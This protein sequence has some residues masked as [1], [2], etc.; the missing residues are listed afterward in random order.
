M[1]KR[2]IRESEIV[3]R[4][5]LS[6]TTIWRKEKRGTFPKRTRIS[7]NA[8]GWDSD[9]FEEWLTNPSAWVENNQRPEAA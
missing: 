2:F 5:G 8:I 4:S 9:E 1:A 6:R 3:V 7:E